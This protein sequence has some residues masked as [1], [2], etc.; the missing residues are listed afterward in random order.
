[1]KI[2]SIN[3][4]PRFKRSYKKLLQKVKDDFDKKIYLFVENPRDPSLG[5]HKLKGNLEECF[6]F[7]LIDG[8]RVL[9]FFNSPEEISFI[10]IGPHDKYQQWSR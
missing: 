7:K 9:F 3:R 5:T 8:F 4:T 1:M 10:D 6:A 2:T